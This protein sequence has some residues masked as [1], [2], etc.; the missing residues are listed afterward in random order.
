MSQIIDLAIRGDT[1]LLFQTDRISAIEP[2]DL[3]VSSLGTPPVPPGDVAVLRDGEVVVHRLPPQVQGTLDRFHILDLAAMRIKRSFGA[4]AVTGI[5]ADGQSVIAPATSGG[6]W[7]GTPHSY[8]LTHWAP[9]GVSTE[10]VRREVSWYPDWE[11]ISLASGREAFAE[12]HMKPKI[13]SIAQDESGYLWVAS[14][15]PQLDDASEIMT[16]MFERARPDVLYD[17]VV[18][19][20]DLEL[21]RVVGKHIFDEFVTLLT[22]DTPLA[23]IRR[24]DELGRIVVEAHT[25]RVT[26]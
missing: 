23:I 13:A 10:I 21:G 1:V 22:G 17:T 3:T 11:P 5:G 2:D 20:M 24:E 4:R 7:S 9:D 8:I 15:L 12:Y 25:M 16:L 18:E 26:Y 14:L 6:L 19:V